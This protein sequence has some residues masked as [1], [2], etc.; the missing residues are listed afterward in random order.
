MRTGRFPCAIKITESFSLLEIGTEDSFKSDSILQ[1]V[2][3]EVSFLKFAYLEMS[4]RQQREAQSLGLTRK[5]ALLAILKTH[6][7]TQRVNI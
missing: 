3:T 7:T 4:I 6:R 2:F 5:R 1:S